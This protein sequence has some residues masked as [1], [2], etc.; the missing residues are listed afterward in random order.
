MK[1]S[2]LDNVL[3][4]NRKHAI[5][6]LVLVAFLAITVLFI[7]TAL[8]EQLPALNAAPE[9]AQTASEPATTTPAEAPAVHLAAR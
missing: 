8:G 4:R 6:D 7:G 2:R 3:R 5:L 9:S 1:T